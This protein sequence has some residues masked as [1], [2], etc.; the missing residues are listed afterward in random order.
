M[1][2]WLGRTPVLQGRVLKKGRP[3]TAVVRFLLR[4]TDSEGNAS[5]AELRGE[6]EVGPPGAEA[7]VLRGLFN[8]HKKMAGY[9][10][11]GTQLP[12]KL[13][14]TNDEKLVIDWKQWERDGGLAAARAQGEVGDAAKANAAVQSGA[15]DTGPP[16][17][18]V[19]AGDGGGGWQQATIQ[20]WQEAVASGHMSEDEFQQAMADLRDAS[21]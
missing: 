5:W 6:L 4:G 13:H 15:P 1:E 3:T 10:R 20:G 8:G 2:M 21:G 16:T 7:T 17:Q 14:P 19:S 12:V 9:V 11:P 18:T